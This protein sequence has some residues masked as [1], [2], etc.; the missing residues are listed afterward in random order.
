MA[1]LKDDVLACLVARD[2]AAIPARVLPLEK[3]AA[4]PRAKR[5]TARPGPRLMWILLA[6]ATVGLGAAAVVVLDGVPPGAGS[7]AGRPGRGRLTEPGPL[8][9]AAS[10]PASASQGSAA[11]SPVRAAPSPMAMLEIIQPTVAPIS[12]GIAKAPRPLAAH[13]SRSSSL[14]PRERLAARTTGSTTAAPLAD[15]L[16]GRA[17]STAPSSAEWLTVGQAAF[18]KGNFPESVRAARA[19]LAG[20]SSA[21]AYLLL[22]DTYFKMER[23]S[24]AVREYS[25]ALALAPD[26]THARRGRD[27]ATS[28]AL[29]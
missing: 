28:R 5:R 27:L 10:E 7:L 16:G 18:A 3:T 23:F 15:A 11:E 17:S 21:E 14:S 20:A 8:P 13:R 6:G 19:S 1:E 26:N 29:H 4:A 25:A 24:D 9:R 12:P 22:G 2:A